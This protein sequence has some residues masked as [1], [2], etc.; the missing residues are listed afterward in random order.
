MIVVLALT[1]IILG[2]ACLYIAA[3]PAN[4]ALCRQ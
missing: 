1:L 3:F 4:A 2:C